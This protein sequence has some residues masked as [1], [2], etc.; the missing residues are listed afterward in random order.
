VA[1][2]LARLDQCYD[3]YV[4]ISALRHYFPKLFVD[5]A[6]RA[7]H[8]PIRPG[9][10]PPACLRHIGTSWIIVS[11]DRAAFVM[12]CG[13]PRVVEALKRMLARDELRAVEGLWVTHYHDDHVEA[14]P[15][16]QEAFS[17][18]CITDQ[19]VAQVIRNPLAW[20]LPCISA[21]RARVDRPTRD[22]DSW[23]W[24]EFKLTAY[25]FPGQTLYHA[26]LLAEGQGVRM[27]FV[28]DSFTM[29]GIDDY[30]PQNRNPFGVGQGFDRCIALLDRLRPT[31][32]FNCHVNEAFDFTAEECSTM[33]ANLA[34]REQLFRE[35]LP[36]DH[37]N[38]GTDDSW[39]RAFPYEQERPAGAT[40]DFSLVLTN[41]SS[42][43]REASCRA[44]LPRAW[45]T[46]A[47]AWSPATIP[48]GHDGAIRLTLRIPP[49]A[50]PGRYVIPID[51]RYD[52]WRLPQWTE[53]IV[54]VR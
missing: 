26:G 50:V 30:C 6:G 54:V 40:A 20:R 38:Y 17:C 52:R 18:P 13:T 22:G 19:G 25:Q 12:D 31:H 9:K 24:H 15:Q 11:R 3:R 10:A 39:A 49:T 42:G 21:S 28:G 44:I 23:T 41:Y 5:Y 45:D 35:L 8:M 51:V 29:A 43:P 47:T 4:A 53:A 7:D 34:E 2:L 16:F 32:L 1:T 48:A 37:P 33:R 46:A 36:W 14:I 27:C